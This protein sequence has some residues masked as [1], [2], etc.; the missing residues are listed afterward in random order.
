M[1]Q[2][3]T[4]RFSSETSSAS[5]S[6][7]HSQS[8]IQP[9]FDPQ[10][11]CHTSDVLSSTSAMEPSA[12]TCLTSTKSEDA[13]APFASLHLCVSRSQ[14]K[15]QLQRLNRNKAAGPDHVSPRADCTS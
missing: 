14:A 15:M 7:A 12:S 10:R 8:D 5:S 9:S 3:D 11:S 1:I 4:L 2:I 6:P 13:D